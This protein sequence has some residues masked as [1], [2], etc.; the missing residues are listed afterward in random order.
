MHLKTTETRELPAT[1]SGLIAST[2]SIQRRSVSPQ[3]LLRAC[4]ALLLQYSKQHSGLY[5]EPQD[6]AGH[7]FH[8][9]III[10]G[11]S[12]VFPKQSAR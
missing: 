6:T 8:P 5:R 9:S 7:G 1:M 2:K 10:P 4:P 3:A 12:A 11:I